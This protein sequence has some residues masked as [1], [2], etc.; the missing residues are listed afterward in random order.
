MAP[1]HS[2]GTSDAELFKFLRG[3][4]T[5]CIEPYKLSGG[6]QELLSATVI[7]RCQTTR[8]MRLIMEFR[9]KDVTQDIEHNEMK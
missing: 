8:A 6:V 1:W 5:G 2:S 4:R 7:Q 3:F 9:E